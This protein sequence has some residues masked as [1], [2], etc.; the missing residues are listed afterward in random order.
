M[1]EDELV[2]APSEDEC[3]DDLSE[4]D[5]DVP[6]EVELVLMEANSAPN[7]DDLMVEQGLPCVPSTNNSSGDL[8]GGVYLVFAI[9]CT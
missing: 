1:W 9:L 2:D 4:D 6:L 7:F 8:M 3:L 5:E